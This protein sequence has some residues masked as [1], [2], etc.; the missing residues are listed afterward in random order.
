[1]KIASVVSPDRVSISAFLSFM[2]HCLGRE[3]VFGEIHH[4]MTP[5]DV[6]F[7]IDAL[8]ETK[9]RIL[10][11]Y[12]CSKSDADPMQ[13]VPIRLFEVSDFIV[14]MSLYSMDWKIIKD[15]IPAESGPLQDRWKLNLSKMS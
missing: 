9:E 7:Y 3:Y 4:L 15:G 12:Y 8:M 1:M 2:R 11:S 13:I 10:F 6:T 5:K 14:W